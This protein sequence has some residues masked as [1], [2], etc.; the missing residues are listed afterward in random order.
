MTVGFLEET[1]TL[2]VAVQISSSLVPR[3][4]LVMLQK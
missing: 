3:V 1:E 4:V 2:E